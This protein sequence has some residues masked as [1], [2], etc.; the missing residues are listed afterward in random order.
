MLTI[1]PCYDSV[2][3]LYHLCVV[4]TY[5]QGEVQYSTRIDGEPDMIWTSQ[6]DFEMKYSLTIRNAN[7]SQVIR[8]NTMLH[9]LGKD[10]KCQEP[11]N[12]S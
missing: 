1:S 10:P 3:P 5:Y 6:S 8:A 11:S 12:I 2:I 7:Y 9:S 4:A